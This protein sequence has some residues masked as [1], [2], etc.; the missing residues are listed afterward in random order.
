MQPIQA[1]DHSF[2]DEVSPNVQPES[3]L[4]QRKAIP[5]HSISGYTGEEANP[6][7][8]TASL[9]VVACHR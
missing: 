2:R 1:H 9:Q 4:E 8:T 5:S 7:L 6:H 3:P